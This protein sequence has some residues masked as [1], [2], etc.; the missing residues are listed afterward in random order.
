M[1]TKTC[2]KCNIEKPAT[3]EFFRPDKRYKDG[4][5]SWCRKCHNT[6]NVNWNSNN[7]EK[8]R[9]HQKKYYKTLRG[10]ITN[11]MGNIKHR[12]TN[13]N[14]IKYK[15]YGGRGIECLFTSEALFDWVVM[16]N[17]EP[18]GRD[19]HRIDNDGNYTLDNVEFM[20]GGLHIS[21]HRQLQEG[22]KI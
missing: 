9:K 21:L 1:N 17:I 12:C 7:P 6:A 10:Y 3:K 15:Y 22:A 5:N 4:F 13:L 2:T 20:D 11:L 19:I 16:N 8:C 18:R 14:S